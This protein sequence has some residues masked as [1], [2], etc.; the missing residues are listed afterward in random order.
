MAGAA[1]LPIIDALIN[2]SIPASKPLITPAM[3]AFF[4][5]GDALP[6]DCSDAAVGGA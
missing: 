5:A 1:V 6:A 3:I 2:P 4:T